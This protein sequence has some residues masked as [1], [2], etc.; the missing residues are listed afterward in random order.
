MALPEESKNHV[1]LKNLM[2]LD[3]IKLNFPAI[4]LTYTLRAIF[5]RK[6]I[7]TIHKIS[8][9]LKH[10]YKL[11]YATLLSSDEF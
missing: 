3:L 2:N 1:I 7:I 4:Q 6:K 5:R 8:N 11:L 10:S 9:K